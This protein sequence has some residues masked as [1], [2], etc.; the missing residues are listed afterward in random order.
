MIMRL[1][2]PISPE[3][4][5]SPV[6]FSP[7]RYIFTHT[8]SLVNKC[9]ASS[10][11]L[12]IV[13]ACFSFSKRVRYTRVD[14]SFE[15]TVCLFDESTLNWTLGA[16][17]FPL[18]PS[19]PPSLSLS[20]SSTFRERAL[21]WER[22]GGILRVNCQGSCKRE[23]FF[24]FFLF[25]FLLFLILEV[26]GMTNFRPVCTWSWFFR[27]KSRIFVVQMFHYSS[28]KFPRYFSI[29]TICTDFLKSWNCLDFSHF[30][31]F[32]EIFRN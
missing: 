16:S 24:F 6:I 27:M 18:F 7:S 28:S 11:Q 22:N 26:L 1:K 25:F 8:L 13:S 17:D 29:S 30:L 31:F 12:V 20:S 9:L 19:L 32:K 21:F 3:K 2:R 23:Y 14:H 5:Y 4:Y 10:I 15:S